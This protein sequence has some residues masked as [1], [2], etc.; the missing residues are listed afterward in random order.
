MKTY[1]LYIQ[2]ATDDISS[3]ICEVCA[4]NRH[5]S[6][7]CELHFYKV[8]L[9][10]SIG[11]ILFCTLRIEKYN[12][13]III[14]RFSGPCIVSIFVL[15]YFQQDA[16]LHSFFISGKLLYMFRVVSSPIIRSTYNCIYSIWNL[17]TVRDKNKLLVICIQGISRLWG[18]TAGG[19]FLGLCDQKSS[20]KHVSDLGQLRSYDRFL[21]PVHA[22]V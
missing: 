22:L 5:L 18:I 13:K 4:T 9:L 2:A 14:L 3:S 17:L 16:T 11:Y 7:C 19:D 15:I 12:R 21:I 10:L 20:Y 8:F 6:L 1:G